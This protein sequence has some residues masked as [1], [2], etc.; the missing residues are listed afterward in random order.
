MCNLVNSQR[1]PTTILFCPM[2]RA[3]WFS[4]WEYTSEKNMQQDMRPG[5]SVPKVEVKGHL[6]GFCFCS[7]QEDL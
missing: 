3:S 6:H 5:D 1:D 4:F 7:L 2:I